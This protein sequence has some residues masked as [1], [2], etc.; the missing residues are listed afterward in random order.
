MAEFGCAQRKIQACCEVRVAL[1]E[2]YDAA[3]HFARVLHAQQHRKSNGA[4]YMSH[5]LEVSGLTLEYGGDER[6]AVAALLH[7]A[8][9]DQADAF[10]GA[11]LLR[12]TI[13]AQFGAEVL[14]LVEICTDCDSKP[15]PAWLSRKQNHLIRLSQAPPYQCLVPACDKLH[16]LRCVNSEIRAGRD[17]MRMLKGGR[18]EQLWHY[19]AVAELFNQKCPLVAK[20]LNPE[21]AQFLSFMSHGFSH[22]K[23]SPA[24]RAPTAHAGRDGQA[25]QSR[26]APA[27]PKPATVPASA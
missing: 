15:K 11:A 3:L 9:E 1:S 21:I 18:A 13:L 10:G 5:L 4:P 7:D 2:S 26:P 20:D 22:D 8:I 23:R 17:P 6:Q 27:A 25:I 19:S 12:R 24:H 16:N 14:Q